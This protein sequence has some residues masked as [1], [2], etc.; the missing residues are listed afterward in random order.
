MSEEDFFLGAEVV[1]KRDESK[2][3]R[4]V[5]WPQGGPVVLSAGG[6]TWMVSESLLDRVCKS[7]G[8]T[9]Q[10]FYDRHHQT[11]DKQPAD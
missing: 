3:L 7:N 4:I 2:P 1:T 10:K 6:F 8:D 9:I 11:T 5:D